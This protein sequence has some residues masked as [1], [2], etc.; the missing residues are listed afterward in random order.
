MIQISKLQPGFIWRE[1]QVSL[2]LL[3]NLT[4]AVSASYPVFRTKWRE[5]N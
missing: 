3:S 2:V 1:K 4:I 5:I